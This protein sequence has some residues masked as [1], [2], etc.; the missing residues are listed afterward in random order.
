MGSTDGSRLKAEVAALVGGRRKPT[1]CCHF[2]V[3]QP[4]DSE[5]R[6]A[7]IVACSEQQAILR[8][9]THFSTRLSAE[10]A[11]ALAMLRA[12]S[13]VPIHWGTI[14]PIGSVWK[15]MAYLEDPPH[16]FA[17]AAART[18]PLT[19]V[20]VLSPGQSTVVTTPVVEPR[21]EE[22]VARK[23]VLAPAAV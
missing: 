4:I 23:V 6:L 8:N 10:A 7:D 1:Q 14:H 17:R 9:A 11:D 18:A 16:E 13:A 12:R 15:N 2:S 21:F 3:D 19:D 22:M 20:R 5:H